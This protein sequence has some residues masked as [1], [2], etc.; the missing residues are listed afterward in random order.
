[1]Y[2]PRK[3]YTGVGLALIL[4]DFTI[5][6]GNFFVLQ[7]EHPQLNILLSAGLC[8]GSCHSKQFIMIKRIHRVP[9]LIVHSLQIIDRSLKEF[10]PKAPYKASDCSKFSGGPILH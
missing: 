5:K 8:T 2:S 9:A 1:M 7:I 4:T 3:T 6:A 10:H